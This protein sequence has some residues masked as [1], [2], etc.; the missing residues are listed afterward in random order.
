[1]GRRS[2][3]GQEL[4]GLVTVDSSVGWRKYEENQ[5]YTIGNEIIRTK[6]QC[7]EEKKIL[8]AADFLLSLMHTRHLSAAV[9]F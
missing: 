8:D 9:S 5:K 7:I 1:M 4:H 2:S 3:F 6:T